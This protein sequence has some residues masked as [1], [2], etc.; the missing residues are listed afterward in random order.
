MFKFL[1]RITAIIATIALIGAALKSALNW[2]ARSEEDDYEVFQD[3]ENDI[4]A[5]K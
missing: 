5:E 4:T 1:R 3:D 2:L